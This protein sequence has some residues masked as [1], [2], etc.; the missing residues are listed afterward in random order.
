ML[1]LPGPIRMIPIR[2]LVVLLGL[3]AGASAMAAGA[4]ML[5]MRIQPTPPSDPIAAGAA[6]T[7]IQPPPGVPVHPEILSVSDAVEGPDGS[8]VILDGRSARW[9]RVSPQG[10]VEVSA[11]RPG[12]GPG[13]L[14][15]PVGL[16]LMGDTVVVGTRTAGTVERFLIDGRP[17]DRIGVGMPGCAAGLLRRLVVAGGELHLLR[18]CLDP[19]SGGSTMQVHRLLPSGNLMVVA[20]RAWTDLTG[21]RTIR[22]GRPILA[23]GGDLLLFG[24]ATEDCLLVLLPAGSSQ[25]RLCHPA[26]PRVPLSDPERL[27]AEEVR[28]RLSARGLSMEVPDFAPS[29]DAAFAGPPPEVVFRTMRGGERRSLDRLQGGSLEGLPPEGLWSPLTFV[30]VSSIFTAGETMEGTWLLVRSRE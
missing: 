23:G 18:E 9:H 1:P 2:R 7:A 28:A 6:E 25:E 29:F 19:E 5:W 11:G 15:N 24:D 8:W 26:P 21:T 27:Q 20:S 17:L 14:R 10:V 30:G 16:A 3:F 4:S 12:E 13:E 22:T